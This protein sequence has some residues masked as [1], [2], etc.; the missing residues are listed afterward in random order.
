MLANLLIEGTSGDISPEEKI[1][2]SKGPRAYAVK[3]KQGVEDI[4]TKPAICLIG[5]PIN[6]DIV[7]WIRLRSE[8]SNNYSAVFIPHSVLQGVD[9]NRSKAIVGDVCGCYVVQGLL[10]AFNLQW[11][12][13]LRGH[14]AREGKEGIVYASPEDFSGLKL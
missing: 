2:V 13:T 9:R 3:V 1:S 7:D 5:Y 4:P 10:P 11:D 6:K 12:M 8:L 14:L